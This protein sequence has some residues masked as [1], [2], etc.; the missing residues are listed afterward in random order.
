M[1]SI[2]LR[3]ALGIVLLAAASLAAAD[4][5]DPRV[6]SRVIDSEIGRSLERLQISAAPPA[7]DAEFVRRAHLDVLGRIPTAEEA[8][9]F[10]DDVAPEKRRRLIDALMVHA[11]MPVW[12]SRVIHNGLNGSLAEPPYGGDEF[13]AFLEQAM[14]ENRP[15]ND[16]VRD[17]LLPDDADPVRRNAAWFI[18]SRYKGGDKREQLDNV[19]TAVA[20]GLFGVQ[21]QCAKCHDHPFVDEWKQGHFYGLAAFLGRTEPFKVENVQ[22]L[23]ERADGEVTFVTTNHEE[24][25]ARLMFLDGRLIDEPPAAKGDD[26]YLIVKGKGG[27]P[28][29]PKFSRRA[30]L[31]AQALN[32]DSPYLRQAMVNRVW[33]QLMG[34]GLVEPVDQIHAANPPSHPKL[35][36]TLAED[37][38]AHGFELKRL[39][40]GILHSDAYQR[41]TRWDRP[42]KRPEDHA[43]ATAVLKPLSP[44]QWA[45]SL[46]LATGH[47]TAFHAKL[48]REKTKLKLDVVT[49]AVARR[50]WERERD[51]SVIV[52]RFRNESETYQVPVTQPLFLAYND[53]VKRML[54]PTADNPM[55]RLIRL[56]DAAAAEAVWLGTL[57]R[58]PMSEETA[59]FREYVGGASDRVAALRDVIRAVLSGEEFRFTP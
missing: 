27:R 38:A 37:F 45:N 20:S 1:N 9:Q 32:A 40:A 50:R 31:V 8:K 16:V 14:R 30:A 47:F 39:I 26:A 35:F 55:N 29:V 13:I 53:V 4:D 3:P 5:E 12:W 52:E 46:S 41:S 10:L 2:L 51:Y 21:L 49:V 48:E 36:E 56:E 11:E 22:V 43:Y 24:K 34:R 25:T 15:W 18:A 58:R 44:D 23:S 6:V 7:S 57:A 33:K 42:G 28:G 19:T 17:M 59:V 54:Q